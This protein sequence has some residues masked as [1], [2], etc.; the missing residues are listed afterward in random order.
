MNEKDSIDRIA[1]VVGD[2]IQSNAKIVASHN[3]AM[4]SNAD[5]LIRIE[6][7]QETMAAAITQIS[8]ASTKAIDCTVRLETTFAHLEEKAINKMLVIEDKVSSLSNGS[9]VIDKRLHDLEITNAKREGQTSLF[10][11][12]T[13]KLLAW[14]VGAVFFFGT[15]YTKT[16][17]DTPAQIEHR[18]TESK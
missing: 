5:R 7:G 18:R 14:L 2:L 10:N 8:E 11:G 9:V 6:I 17:P 4:A 16:K 1:S 12:D 13:L 15:I 3:D